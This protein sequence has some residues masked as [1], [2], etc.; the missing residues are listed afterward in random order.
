MSIGAIESNLPKG[1]PKPDEGSSWK[2]PTL[3]V[4]KAVLGVLA[5]SAVSTGAG[6]A[7]QLGGIRLISKTGINASLTTQV[8]NNVGLGLQQAGKGLFSVGKYAFLS[9][10]VPTYAVVYVLPKWILNEGL[11]KMA[12][13]THQYVIIP[14]YNGVIQVMK[15]FSERFIKIVQAIYNHVLI[16]IGRVIEKAA[17]WT[18][19]AVIIPVINKVSQVAIALKD[20]IVH[21]AQAIYNHVLAPVGRVIEKAAIWT[22]KAVIVPIFNGIAQGCGIVKDLVLPVAHRVYNY[23]LKPLGQF[24]GQA[25]RVATEYTS[26]VFTAVAGAGN[27]VI[28]STYETYLRLTGRG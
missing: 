9:I 27:A 21:V 19:K 10:A 17:L 8:A 26:R 23:A 20:T 6:K 14:V 16:P 11:P 25:F 28:N 7:M 4:G 13:L 3:A 5:F 1:I 18:W 2:N 24:I 15:L 22:W 12:R